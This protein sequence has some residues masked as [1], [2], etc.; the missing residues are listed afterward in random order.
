[1]RRRRFLEVALAILVPGTLLLAWEFSSR[2]QWIDATAY[3]A[4]SRIIQASQTLIESGELQTHTLATLRRILSGY[5][6]GVFAGLFVGAL[7]GSSRLTRKALE[8]VLSA[9][10]VVPKLALLPI[11]LTV[12]GFSDVSKIA[13]VT[14]SVF[15]YIWIQTMESVWSVPVGFREAGRSLGVNKMVMLWHVT[16]P[17][18]LPQVFVAMRMGM[19]AAVLV[20]VAA[21]FVSGNT[22]LGYLIFHSRALFL[23]ERTYVGIVAVSLLGMILT[24]IVV[25]VGRF[26]TPWAEQPGKAIE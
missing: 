7:M 23:M 6:L 18:A 14:V 1:M 5:G 11:F 24:W 19:V 13:I 25:A 9:L 20:T 4:P 2:M 16:R 22:G 3:P 8:P 17:Y 26:L 10:Y 21:E 15:F 12:F